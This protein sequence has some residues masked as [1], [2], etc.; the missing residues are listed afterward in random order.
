MFKS[1][2][3]P[4][5][6]SDLSDKATATAVRFARLNQAKIVAI[7]VIQPLPFSSM[8]DSGAV[9]DSGQFATQ[10]QDAARRHIE[11]VAAAA[12]AADI[13]FE[14]VITMSPSPYE[15]IVEAAKKHGCDIIMM[16]S[17]GRTGL[18][19]LF[20]GSETQKVLAHTT[21]PVMVLR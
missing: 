20:L 6:G 4:T 3:L 13:P 2:L 1:I 5:D 21:L 19:R 10:M 7:T 9:I 16:A 18:N 12:L 11:K 14:G 15:E 17:H 8:G